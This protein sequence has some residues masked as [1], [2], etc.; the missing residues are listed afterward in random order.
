MTMQARQSAG[1]PRAGSS[2]DRD[3]GKQSNEQRLV[4]RAA[5]D[6]DHAAYAELV[7]RYSNRI[8]RIAARFAATPEAVNDLAEQIFVRAWDRLDQ[9]DDL[10]DFHTWLYQVAIETC[11]EHAMGPGKR[12][13]STEYTIDDLVKSPHGDIVLGREEIVNVY[14]QLEKL[15]PAMRA[16]LILRALEDTSYRDLSS[17]LRQ[18]VSTVDTWLRHGL[19]AL[20]K[21]LGKF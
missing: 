17:I 19:T 20:K 16:V 15:P 5:L 1:A 2:R 18:P 8:F 6:G 7:S 11:L 4:Q 14:T 12:I 21:P 3:R 10:A 13:L 9:W